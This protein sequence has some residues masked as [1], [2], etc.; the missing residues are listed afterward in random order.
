MP[1][2]SATEQHV[3]IITNGCS[4]VAVP[5][6]T[7]EHSL[8]DD[9]HTP[10]L[11]QCLMTKAEPLLVGT[12]MTSGEPSGM[13]PDSPRQL[14]SETSIPWVSTVATLSRS[15]SSHSLTAHKT[16]ADL[17]QETSPK[18]AP[19]PDTQRSPFELAVKQVAFEQS[20]T[21][22]SALKQAHIASSLRSPF[23]IAAKQMAPEYAP[24]PTLQTKQ[25]TNPKQ[26]SLPNS[27]RSP[28]EKAAEE[29]TCEYI[30]KTTQIQFVRQLSSTQ[31]WQS[32]YAVPLRLLLS[33][34]HLTMP[35]L[36]AYKQSRR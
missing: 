2:A 33:R 32:H 19:P 4:L 25:E 9:K 31:L 15:A 7:C 27:A 28:F 5:C 35:L 34:W 14:T 6:S 24:T 1:Q 12:D 3:C 21:P 29:L 26:A 30:P 20:T 11:L 10:C 8:H 13:L 23:E 22:T 16:S 18:K 36:P 17:K